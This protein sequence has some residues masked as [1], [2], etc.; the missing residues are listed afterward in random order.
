[1]ASRLKCSLFPIGKESVIQVLLKNDIKTVY[2]F[3]SHKSEA[4]SSQCNIPYK[5]VQCMKKILLARF[6]ATPHKALEACD[7]MIGETDYLSTPFRS[8]NS[9]L[10]GGIHFGEITEVVGS[11]ACG[12][13]QF[14]LS[15]ATSIPMHTDYKVLYIDTNGGFSSDRIVNILISKG[16]NQLEAEEKLERIQC[17]QIHDIFKMLSTLEK[18]KFQFK[19]QMDKFLIDVKLIVIDSISTFIA[20]HLSG[21]QSDGLGYLCLLSR[22]LLSIAK[23]EHIAVLVTN[24]TVRGENYDVKPALGKYWS[25]VAHVKLFFKP[26]IHP[27]TKVKCTEICN[28]KNNKMM[29]ARRRLLEV[30]DVIDVIMADDDSGDE[31]VIEPMDV[32]TDSKDN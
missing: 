30:S 5:D 3:L 25:Q 21:S 29:A 13:T 18:L 15:V 19:N 16:F 17:L 7:D 27:K 32:A 2:D 14:C 6:S 1:M 23:R 8:I 9:L 24:S 12:K 10:G 4:I 28:V 26:M 31:G 20:P 11:P 22:T